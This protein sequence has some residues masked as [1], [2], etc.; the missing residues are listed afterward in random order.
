L[1]VSSFDSWVS[2]PSIDAARFRFV[3]PAGAKK[4]ELKALLA[5]EKPQ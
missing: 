1:F 5:G 4:M 3:A 2:N